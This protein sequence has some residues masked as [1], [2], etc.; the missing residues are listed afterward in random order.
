MDNQ[1]SLVRVFASRFRSLISEEWRSP[2]AVAWGTRVALY[3]LIIFFVGLFPGDEQTRPDFW[4]A[5]SQWDGQ[6]YLQIATQGYQWSG[7]TV[8]SD[9]VFWPLYPALGKLVGALVGDLRWGFLIVTNVSFA[10]FLCYLYRLTALDF[11]GPTAERAIVYAAVF[12]GAFVLGAFYTE[13]T[14]FALSVAAFYYAR[15]GHWKLAIALGFLTGLTRLPANAILIPLAYEFWRQRGLRWQMIVLGLVPLGALAFGLYVWWLSGEP[16][17]VITAQYTAW[18]RSSAAPW[19]TLRLALDRATWPLPH[20]VVAVGLLDAG[21]ILLFIGLTVWAVVKLPPAYW[22]Y[23]GVVLIGALSVSMDV[24]KA[25]PTA[26]VSRFLMAIF[27][28][29][30]AL[31]QIARHG[32]IDQMVRWPFAILMGVFAI[33]FFSGFW[34]L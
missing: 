26:S 2:L 9:I 27:P 20:Y 5:V 31:A 22:L 32:W 6:W 3:V 11:D 34:V 16:G 4:K 1:T 15:R 17:A 13:A 28:G 29:Y 18:F 19:E 10:L 8:Q 25:P 33:Y 21:T 12:P 23:A 7:P 24:T 30:I 14:S